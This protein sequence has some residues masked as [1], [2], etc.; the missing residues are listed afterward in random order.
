MIKGRPELEDYS[1]LRASQP[2]RFHDFRA[3]GITWRHARGDNPALI[4]QECGHEDE[5]TNEIYIRRRTEEP[6]RLLRGA[7]SYAQIAP[8]GRNEG[9]ESPIKQCRRRESNPHL[10]PIFQALQRENV[11]RRTVKRRQVTRRYVHRAHAWR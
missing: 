1:D 4:R 8:S 6:E 3:S 10:R 11:N 7:R 9:P 2:I 5:R